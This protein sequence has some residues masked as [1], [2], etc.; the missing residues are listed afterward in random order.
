MIEFKLDKNIET[1]AI[2][3]ANTTGFAL[4]NYIDEYYSN[5]NIKYF[6]D[7]AAEQIGDFC[8]ITTLKP[9]DFFPRA[10]EVD[11]IIIAPFN[12]SQD[13]KHTLL[14]N[15]IENFTILEDNFECKYIEQMLNSEEERE[16]FRAVYTSRRL[17]NELLFT[18]YNKERLQINSQGYANANQYIEFINKDAIKTILDCGGQNGYTS[19][20]FEHEIPCAQK[21]YCFEPYYEK[22]ATFVPG[23]KGPSNLYKDIVQRSNKIEII[24]K[25]VWS[26]ETTLTFYENTKS[27]GGSTLIPKTKED[28]YIKH[29]IKTTTIDK[30]KR[31]KGIDK[32]DFIKMDIESAELNALKGG[33]ETIINDRPQLAISIYHTLMEYISI[34]LYLKQICKD[35]EFHL[36]NYSRRPAETV[37]YAIPKE[38]LIK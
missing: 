19:I 1:V 38:L 17:R 34:P 20:V 9:E 36:G 28:V 4:K 25:G 7:A 24:E 13:I 16:L 27:P 30:F 32:I 22:F 21:I 35:Y 37:M 2:Y 10:K 6:I 5:V 15:N 33:Y 11:I 3:G 23:I 14:G 29:E 8:D 12:R 31:E 26:E 18:L